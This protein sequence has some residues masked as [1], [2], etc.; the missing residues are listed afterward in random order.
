MTNPWLEAF[1]F[2]KK[3]IIEKGYKNLTRMGQSNRYKESDEWDYRPEKKL[4]GIGRN[5]SYYDK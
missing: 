5:T 2:P 3:Q 1:L 4:F